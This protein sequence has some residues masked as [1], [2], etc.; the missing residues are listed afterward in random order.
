M[1]SEAFFQILKLNNIELSE[2][3]KRIVEKWSLSVSTNGPAANQTGYDI[4]YKEALQMISIDLNSETPFT[5]QW[6]A[7]TAH[8]DNGQSPLAQARIYLNNGNVLTNS[9]TDFGNQDLQS[10]N[11]AFCGKKET[12][13]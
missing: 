2:D 9:E 8:N 7:R 6:I 13:K 5:D 1:N 3:D 4:K 11:L 12:S 10:R